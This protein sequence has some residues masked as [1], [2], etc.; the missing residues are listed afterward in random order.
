MTSILQIEIFAAFPILHPVLS[1]GT[2][3]SMKPDSSS[4]LYE[5]AIVFTATNLRRA[6]CIAE[7][8]RQAN[9]FKS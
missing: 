9:P 4:N 5:W 3:R 8:E 7:K 6:V 2:A 1:P